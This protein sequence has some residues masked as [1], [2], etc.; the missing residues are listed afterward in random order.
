MMSKLL[1]PY[2]FFVQLVKLKDWTQVKT[3]A[4]IA[5]TGVREHCDLGSP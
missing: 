4:K 1:G 3:K 2:L 5:M